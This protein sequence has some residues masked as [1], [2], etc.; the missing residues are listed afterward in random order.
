MK[1]ELSGGL[2]LEKA[3]MDLK[4]TVAKGVTTRALKKAAQ[5]VADAAERHVPV[6][7]GALKESIEVSTRL[8]RREKRF[9][10][11]KAPDEVRVHVGASYKLGRRGRHSHLVEFGT[12]N[13]AAEPYMRPA[14][15][16]TK[17]QLLADL[18]QSMRVEFDKAVARAQRKAARNAKG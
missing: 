5:P 16:E 15:E 11:R 6:R 17:D 12:V 2:D 10:S 3:L 18:A 4:T 7:T 13:Q 1:L 9:S 14:W 8:A